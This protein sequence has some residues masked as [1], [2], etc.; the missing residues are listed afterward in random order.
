MSNKNSEC[1]FCNED[2]DLPIVCERCKRKSIFVRRALRNLVSEVRKSSS[3]RATL[4][5]KLSVALNVA[6]KSLEQP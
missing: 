1:F 6:E 4:G 3:L 2:E 5:M